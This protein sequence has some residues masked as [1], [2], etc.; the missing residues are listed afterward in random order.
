ML[1][2]CALLC[3]SLYDSHTCIGLPR[4]HRSQ[5]CGHTIL[6]L[7]ISLQTPNSESMFAQSMSSS[8]THAAAEEKTRTIYRLPK[9]EPG[10]INTCKVTFNENRF[11]GSIYLL[12]F[13]VSFLSS[14]KFMLTTI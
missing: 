13:C 14:S 6:A 5:N 2:I 1:Y 12:F 9:C 4:S 11:Y 10:I 3:H 7:C 8:S